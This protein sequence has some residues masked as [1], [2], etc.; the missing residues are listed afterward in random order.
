MEVSCSSTIANKSLNT[1]E[2]LI[3]DTFGTVLIIKV[4]VYQGFELYKVSCLGPRNNLLFI[5]VPLF[6]PHLEFHCT[7][8]Q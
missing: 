1:G 4:S 2:P 5:E 8:A 7:N 6:S 3:V